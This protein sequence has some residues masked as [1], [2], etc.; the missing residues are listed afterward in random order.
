MLKNATV[1]ENATEESRLRPEDA[2]IVAC[3]KTS[4][5][6]DHPS[7]HVPE[8]EGRAQADVSASSDIPRRLRNASSRAVQA[9][10]SRSKQLG[11]VSVAYRSG[12]VLIYGFG[13]GKRYTNVLEMLRTP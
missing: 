4:Y 8:A 13:I 2:R 11:L 3:C 7:I 12:L 1:L 5:R 9:A 6:L 10:G